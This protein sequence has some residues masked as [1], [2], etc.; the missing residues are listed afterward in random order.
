MEM[1]TQTVTRRDDLGEWPRRLLHVPTMTSHEWEPGNR[2]GSFAE[3][4]FNVVSYTWG[5]YEL[6]ESNMPDIEAVTIKGLTWNVPRIDPGHFAGEQLANVARKSI[7]YRQNKPMPMMTSGQLETHRSPQHLWLDVACI[8]QE[9]ED[10]KISEIARQA[11]IFAKAET[12][13][14]WLSHHQTAQLQ[15]YLQEF[16]SAIDDL[17]SSER[18]SAESDWAERAFAVLTQLLQDPWF[19][20]LWTLQKAFLRK[21]ALLLSAQGEAIHVDD[22]GPVNLRVL[23]LCCFPLSIATEPDLN[24]WIHKAHIP[25]ALRLQGLIRRSGLG[26][27][28]SDNPV[29]L[30]TGARFRQTAREVDRVYGIMQ[31]FKFRLGAAAPQATKKSFELVELEDQLGAALLEKWPIRSQMHVH[32]EAAPYGRAWRIGQTSELPE[33]VDGQQG[34]NS[35]T[36]QDDFGKP[37]CQL[38]TLKVNDVT[39]GFFQ[40]IVAVFCELVISWKSWSGHVPH[41]EPG[42]GIIVFD[43]PLQTLALDTTDALSQMPAPFRTLNQRNVPTDMQDDMCSA[44]VELFADDL[45]V[46][47]L[48]ESKGLILLKRWNSEPPHWHR[49]GI[50]QWHNGVIEDDFLFAR[51]HRK[52]QRTE[53]L[54][55]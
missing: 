19:S 20:S 11:S 1:P 31:I 45:V 16:L 22:Y 35:P 51:D 8:D 7:T 40:G 28:H 3:P 32:M 53:G 36:D 48:C 30:Y 55:G 6:R 38:S 17:E 10:V 47:A 27:L 52:W 2:Y 50:C 41:K 5:R 21:D 49:I 24:E 15:R 26:L 39:W 33:L 54:F 18:D 42:G 46:L 13:L 44:L 12:A 14:I 34:T 9:D 25:T 4:S 37:L 29:T 43:E 23:T